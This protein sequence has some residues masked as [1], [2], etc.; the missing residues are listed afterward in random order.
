M[1]PVKYSFSIITITILLVI[2]GCCAVSFLSIN[3][4]P[5]AKTKELYVYFSWSNALAEVIEREVTTEIEGLA[6]T[7]KGVKK[8]ESTSRNGSGNVAITLDPNTN[9]KIAKFE[10]SA[11]LRSAA[12]KF[13]EDVSLPVVYSRQASEEKSNPIL[14]YTIIGNGSAYHIQKIAKRFFQKDLEKIEGLHK[15][16]FN[17]ATTFELELLFDK[18]K[19]QNHGLTLSDIRRAVSTHLKKNEELGYGIELDNKNKRSQVFISLKGRELSA[20]DWNQIFIKK[21]GDRIIYLK[22]I[23]KSQYKEIEKPSFNRINGLNTISM[24]VSAIKKINQI[25]LAN[26]VKQDIETLEKKLPEGYALVLQLDNTESVDK[27]INTIIKRVLLSAIILLLLTFLISRNWR[28]L[29][30]VT[31]GLV[32][33]LCIA[34]IFYYLLN[35]DIHTYS[36]AGITISFGIMI[37]NVIIMIDHLKTKKN[38]NVFLAILAATLTTVGVL[39]VIYFLDDVS[40]QTLIDFALVIIINILIS[41][42]VALFI[43]PALMSQF[44]IKAKNKRILYK[45]KRKTVVW[46]T[47]YL[48]FINFTL[49]RKKWLVTIAILGFGIPVFLLPNRINEN[50]D[51]WHIKLYNTIFSS[52]TYVKIKPVVDYS[53]GGALRLFMQPNGVAPKTMN[54]NN[55]DKTTMITIGIT[56][57]AGSTVKQINVIAGKFEN[58]L[59]QYQEISKFTA[60]GGGTNANIRVFFKKPHDESGFPSML[61]NNLIHLATTIGGCDVTVQGVGKGFDNSLNL[62]RHNMHM[63]IIGYNYD[64]TVGF[65]HEAKKMLDKQF[66]VEKSRVNRGEKTYKGKVSYEYVMDLNK[67]RLIEENVTPSQ[68]LTNLSFQTF[69]E[70]R[71]GE[72]KFNDEYIPVNIRASTSEESDKWSINN[73]LNATTRLKVVGTLDKE[74]SSG[75]ITKLNQQYKV[76][77]D[78]NYIGNYMMSNRVSERI[79]DTLNLKLPLG[80]KAQRANNLPQLRSVK[81]TQTL[82]VILVIFIVYFIC[83]ILLES[84]IQPFIITLMIPLS[85]IGIFLTFSLFGISF[86]V[87]GYASFLLTS[88]LV[89]NSALYIFNDYNNSIKKGN[90]SIKTIHYIKAY[91]AKIIPILLTVISSIVGFLPFLLTVPNEFFWDSLAAGTIGGLVVS[92]LVLILYLPL[93]LL[94]KTPREQNKKNAITLEQ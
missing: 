60:Q 30:L 2:L 77:V 23:V 1:K 70:N 72:I 31:A 35:I 59:T 78:Y 36:L 21:L 8:I 65:A 62:D 16:D 81:K 32:A 88:G 26:Q 73:K 29:F 22:D 87:G 47:Y 45:R 86:D 64:A 52:K 90:N 61:K 24:V 82:L 54:T 93:F 12:K 41:L 80:F 25:K 50:G 28:Y 11:L 37:D 53:L 18:E 56:T 13:P 92:I 48:N 51:Q 49:R 39:S 69:E 55:K 58:Y 63:D 42:A 46:N 89:V 33:N 10:L 17:G 19:L 74:P 84:L 4:K 94:W 43:I 27:E 68:L 44:P 71:L 75:F 6:A 40:K 57:P 15:V 91:N 66:R 67:E 79:I 9:A 7:I 34:F 3:E 14:S 5:T 85:F 20:V 76:T 38:K 83:A